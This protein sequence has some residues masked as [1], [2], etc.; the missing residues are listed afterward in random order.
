VV[1][2]ANKPSWGTVTGAGDYM[3]DS[4]AT[5]EAFASAIYYFI[6]WNDGNTDN[7]RNI[8]V[9]QDTNFTA[10]FDTLKYHVAVTANESNWGTVTGEGDYMADSTAIIGAIANPAYY[11]VQWTDGVIDNPRNIIVTQD[12]N[13]IAVFDTLKYHIAVTA[14]ESNWGTVTGEGD[15]MADSMATIEAI[16]NQGYRFVQWNNGNTDNPRNI[17][18]MQDTT[19]TAIFESTIGITNKEMSTISVYPNPATDNI[20]IILPE[21]VPYAVFTLYDMQGRMLIKR[22][23]SSRDIAPINNLAPGIYIYNV[24]T[25]K[26]S[27]Q[28]RIIKQ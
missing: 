10:K 7:P 8:T 14:N 27:Y 17:T 3:A 1:L 16:A 26:Q 18:V 15:Y 4:T 6:E 20:N 2:T 21:N 24:Q 25:N 22:E 11:F 23:V 28:G 12:I 5:I 9:T 13:F 19:F